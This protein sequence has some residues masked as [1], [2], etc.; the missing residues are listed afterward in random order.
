MTVEEKVDD[1]C[2]Q[3]QHLTEQQTYIIKLL[4]TMVENMPT[5]KRPDFG[6]LLKPIIDHPAMKANP[7]AADMLLQ[8]M[9]TMGG[10][11]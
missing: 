2:N 10:S 1:I 5:G 7:A 9:S 3:L 6:E 11:K 4:E 8:F